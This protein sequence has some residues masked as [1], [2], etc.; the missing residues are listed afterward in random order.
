MICHSFKLVPEEPWHL[1]GSMQVSP[2]RGQ[3]GPQSE[4][5]RP[6]RMLSTQGQMAG[7]SAVDG[8]ILCMSISWTDGLANGAA[9]LKK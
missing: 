3:V 8:L 4:M 7:H 9:E 6:H 1:V 2:L 5:N